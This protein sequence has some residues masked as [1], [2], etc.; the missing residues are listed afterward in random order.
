MNLSE[1]L[2]AAASERDQAVIKEQLLIKK[3]LQSDDPADVLA[4]VKWK[5]IQPREKVNIK[6]YVIDPNDSSFASQGFAE[7]NLS[8]TFDALRRMSYT[9]IIR[10][11]INTRVEQVATFTSPQPDKYS[12]GFVIERINNKTK[13]I[14]TEDQRIIENLT[15]TVLDCGSLS[16]KWHGDDF[17]SL[18]RK[19]TQDTLV[20][21]ALTY[22]IIRNRKGIPVEIIATDASTF[23][24]AA[25]PTESTLDK[26]KNN[27]VKGYL[28]TVVQIHDGVIYS[29]FYPWELCYGIRNPTTS[30]YNHGYGVSELECL[31]QTVTYMLWADQYNGNFFKQGSAP[32]GILNVKG[33]IN[34]SSLN[35][36]KQH[37]YGQVAGVQNAHRIPVLQGDMVEFI[38]LQ[39]SSKDMEFAKFHE[40]L[41][42][43]ACA[44]YKI[45]PSEVGFNL[46]GSSEQKPLFDSNN[47]ARL[48]Y[49]KDKG[50]RPLLKA[51]E[52]HLNKY[53]V[54]AINKDFRLKFV[55]LESST[56]E[57]ELEAHI[58]SMSNFMTINEIRELRGLKKIKGGDIIANSYYMQSMSQMEQQNQQQGFGGDDEGGD[59]DNDDPWMKYLNSDNEGVEEEENP[60]QKGL[61]TYIEDLNKEYVV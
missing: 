50:L 32:K 28:P 24:L 54:S 8:I 60:F 31:V 13:R 22:E 53:L 14:T 1:E 11:I 34:Q 40:Y 25:P 61:E 16:N 7:K 57:N 9:P 18:L 10:S 5:D 6:S 36:F 33:E 59:E 56:A 44:I 27:Q 17:D 4:A 26:A 20:Y 41:I 58:K 29:E 12:P 30:I 45:D 46:G 51:H 47:E 23:R 21:D 2:R 38:N 3:G 49:S 55:G 48:K 43:V 42:K 39:M 37:W 15:Q 35:Q 52:M 19:L